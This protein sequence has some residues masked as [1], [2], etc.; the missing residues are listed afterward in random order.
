MRFISAMVLR[1]RGKRFRK[2]F[3]VVRELRYYIMTEDKL[4][5]VLFTWSSGDASYAIDNRPI[6]QPIVAQWLKDHEKA[7]FEFGFI[8]VNI[9]SVEKKDVETLRELLDELRQRLIDANKNK[10]T[11]AVQYFTGAPLIGFVRAVGLPG[12]THG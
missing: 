8:D 1:N 12:G 3:D 2:L 10:A 9:K 5:E 11:L 4:S 7:L 6:G